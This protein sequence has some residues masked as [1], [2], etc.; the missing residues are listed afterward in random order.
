MKKNEHARDLKDLAKSLAIVAG[1][2][3][4]HQAAKIAGEAAQLV[5]I[6]ET[7]TFED[8]AAGLMALAG[9]LE[10]QQA[11]QTAQL[12]L[13]R[14][15]KINSSHYLR[16][17]AQG[18]EAVVGKMESQQASKVAGEAA[19]I[20]LDQNRSEE[21]FKALTPMLK[22][23]AGKMQSRQAG[24]TAQV[25]LTLQAKTIDYGVLPL[26]TQGLEA[27]AGQMEPE[28]AG[29]TVH[30]F[31][32]QKIKTTNAEFRLAAEFRPALAKG[33]EIVAAR[34]DK[35]G[36]VNT[37]KN[38]LCVDE[39]QQIILQE[40]GKRSQ[41]QFAGLWDFVEW[42]QQHE[43]TLDLHSPWQPPRDLVEP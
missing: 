37:L 40:L 25:L 35:P 32:T 18:L 15:S 21:E 38:P 8:L 2:M 27:V 33:L 24:K 14:M 7:D 34:L 20:L 19:Q 12:L 13:T 29:E 36:L 30:L 42:A 23:F 31:L 43:P 41:Q 39:A 17:L 9:R 11:V 3:E 16:I 6:A 4:P 26:W 1:K 22:V 28:Q 5:V 10:S